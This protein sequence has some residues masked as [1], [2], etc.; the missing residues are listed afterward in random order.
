[1]AQESLGYIKL[2]WTCPNCG[3]RNPGPQ[4]TC[5]SCGAAQPE[6]VQFRQAE[7][8]NLLKDEAEIEK[9]KSGAD[10]HCPYCSARNVAG[11][12]TCSQCGGD[13]KEG[14]R[15]ETGQVVGAYATGAVKQISCPNCGA[16]NPETALK[17]AGCGASLTR[18]QKPTPQAQ[19]PAK[20][21]PSS[22]LLWVILGILGLGVICILIFSILGGRTEDVV[23][24]VQESS[25]MTSIVVE[26]LQPAI[27]QAWAE[28]IPSDAISIGDCVAKIHHTQA[29][30]AANSEKV[31]GTPYTVDLGSGYAEVVQDCEYQV[32]MDYCEYTVM[33][34]QMADTFT[35]QDNNTQ[36]E[37]PAVQLSNDQRVGSQEAVYTI[38]FNTEDD[39]FTYTTN[40]FDL[41]QQC[42]P[43]SEWILTINAF[44]KIEAI[45]TAQ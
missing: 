7:T 1:M 24:T 42:Q 10:I 34:W 33:E 36:P 25:W 40:D 23:G 44:N 4:K 13:L 16:Q 41:Y 2:E 18:E 3:S 21:A 11:A 30:P 8:Q 17:C 20:K 15:R 38:I 32:Y 14:V 35:L 29:E 37:W 27:H 43:G 31:C 6:N 39:Q 26:A 28:N 5:L 19:L 22:R 9:A 45:E 12:E